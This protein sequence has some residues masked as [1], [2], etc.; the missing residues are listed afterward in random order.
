ML[1][2]CDAHLRVKKEIIGYQPNLH[3]VKKVISEHQNLKLISDRN[4]S[5]NE[6]PSLIKANILLMSW[7]IDNFPLNIM[8]ANESCKDGSERTIV[9]L[10][11]TVPFKSKK[12]IKSQFEDITN[13]LFITIEKKCDIKNIAKMMK[14]TKTFRECGLQEK[15]AK[16]SKEYVNSD[17]ISNSIIQYYIGN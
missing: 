17:E 5:P 6:H 12:R 1:T 15:S 9:Q 11:S 3:C 8:F 13:E 2:A 10:V 7:T 16:K 14:P 4:V